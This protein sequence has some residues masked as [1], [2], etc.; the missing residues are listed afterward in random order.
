MAC[1]Q[2]LYISEENLTGKVEL[3]KNVSVGYDAHEM[4]RKDDWS[5]VVGNNKFYS[6]Y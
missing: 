2:K 3:M 5:F 1:V 6:P 4:G